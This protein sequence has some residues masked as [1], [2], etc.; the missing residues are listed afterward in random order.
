MLRLYGDKKMKWI[1]R[2]LFELTKRNWGAP[3]HAVEVALFGTLY[4]KLLGITSLED[5][6]L[7]IGTVILIAL[8]IIYEFYQVKY[9]GQRPRGALEDAA[10]NALGLVIVVLPLIG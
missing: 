1:T 4:V 7:M 3:W 2:K 8:T 5:P 6:A 10:C 9:K